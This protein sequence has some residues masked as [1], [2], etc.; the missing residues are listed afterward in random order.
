MRRLLVTSALPYANGHI[1]IGHL[2]EYIET[3]IWV[4]AQRMIDDRRVVYIC[5]DDTHGTAVMLRARKEGRSEV[6]IINEMSEAH[7]KDFADFRVVFDH[8]GST[9]SEENKGYAREIWRAFRQRGLVRSVE[10]EQLYDPVA[11]LFLADRFV[12]GTCPNCKSPDQ[13]GDN[14]DKCGSTYDA[15]ELIDPKSTLSDAKPEL[16]KAEHLLVDIEPEHAFLDVWTQAEG[17]MPRETANYLKGFFLNNPLRAW[18]VSRPAPYFGFEIPDAAGHHFYVWFDAPIGYIASTKQW[19]D[20]VGEKFEDW[21]RSPETEI[22]HVIGKDI[23]KFHTLFW[24][25]M[26]KLGGFTLPRRVQVHGFLTVDGEKMSKSKGTFVMASTYAKHLDPEC[27]RYYYAS[28]LGPSVSDLDLNL[29]EFVN[30]VNAELVNKVVNL[31]SRSSRFLAKTGFAAT[32]PDDEGLFAAGAAVHDDILD[33]YENWDF[34]KVTRIAMELADRANAYIDRAQPW[35]LAKQAGKESDVQAV[36]SIALN[37]Y[38][39]IVT[40][41]APIVPRLAEGSAALL[42]CSFDRFDAVK[43]P[44]TSSPVGAYQHLMK[45]IEPAQVTAMVEESKPAEVPATAAL[46]PE[47]AAVPT[48]QTAPVDDGSAMEKEPLAAICT[49][50]DFTKVDL[51]VARIV[52]AEIVPES[53]KLLR[54]SV[55]LGGEHRRTVFAGIKAYYKPEDLVGRLVIICANLAPRQMKLGKTEVTSEGMVLAAGAAGEA[56]VLSPDSGAK[57]GQRV[58]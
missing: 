43:T 15:T 3:D 11:K 39:Q 20:K 44:L 54:L 58:H 2:V 49:I 12:K 35:A 55:S 50:D 57:P 7:Q 21:W 30:R 13:Y 6:E 22:V 41:L 1:H 9:H 33:A 18:D 25:V 47:A 34:A 17:R 24:P 45:R 23:V 36:S 16:R 19:A 46:T 8:Y 26:L 52:T 32:Y 42:G 28:K 10:V 53:K 27:L 29:E 37:L 40:Y 4:R 5:A 38:R 56:F 48:A 14:C 51:R 31:A